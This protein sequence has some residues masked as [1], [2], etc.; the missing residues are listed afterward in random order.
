[1]GLTSSSGGSGRAE[2]IRGRGEGSR[3]NAGHGKKLCKKC[4]SLLRVQLL[5][6]CVAVR[7]RGGGGD[8]VLHLDGREARTARACVPLLALRDARLDLG[9]EALRRHGERSRL[10]SLFS[11]Q[12]Q[13]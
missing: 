7:R 8:E 10:Q 2:R 11:L 13:V 9:L 6:S 5:Q 1:M 4:G 3:G 12:Q